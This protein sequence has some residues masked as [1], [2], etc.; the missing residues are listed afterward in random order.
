MSS[1]I[2]NTDESIDENK[3]PNSVSKS[4]INYNLSK[5]TSGGT[6][7]TRSSG[8]NTNSHVNLMVGS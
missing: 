1:P 3:N 5:R 4:D 7:A 6:N 2:T 8:S